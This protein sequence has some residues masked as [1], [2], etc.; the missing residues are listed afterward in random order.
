[1]ATNSEISSVNNPFFDQIDDFLFGRLNSEEKERFSL[2]L[3]EN[4]ELKEEVDFRHLMIKGIKQNEDLKLKQALTAHRRFEDNRRLTN[5][6][7]IRIAWSSAAAILVFFVYLQIFNN[8]TKTLAESQQGFIS[9]Y[10]PVPEN[11]LSPKTRGI[12]KETIIYSAMSYYDLHQFEMVHRMLLPLAEKGELNENE[13]FYYAFSL[14][15]DRKFSQA[16]EVFSSITQEDFIFKDYIPIYKSLIYLELDEKAKGVDLLKPI[17]S[18][19]GKFHQLS[20]Q[21]LKDIQ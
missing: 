7:W 18:S 1:M 16:L 5:S 10:A 3:N 14:M 8:N 19:E 4:P 6:M 11:Y 2:Y 13:L 12:S 9:R 17:A 21:I 15:M 20:K